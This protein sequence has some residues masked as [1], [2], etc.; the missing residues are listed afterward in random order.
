MDILQISG[1]SKSFGQNKVIRDLNLT[2]PENTIYGFIGQNGAGKTTTMKMI[3]GFLAPD[4]GEIFVKGEKVSQGKNST[5]KYIGYLPDVPEFYGYM[6]PMEYLSLCGEITGMAKAD[7]KKRANELLE[8]VG[9]AGSK[10]RIHGFSRGMRQRLGVAQ[11]LFNKPAFLICDEPTSALDPLGRKE[12]LDI[13]KSVKGETTVLF[14]THILSDVEKICDRI[15]FLND[16][17]I[18][19][20]GTLEEIRAS[21][22][23]QGLEISFEKAEDVLRFKNAFPDGEPNG[24]LQLIYKRRTKADAACFMKYIAENNI[25]IQR[26][27]ILEPTLED[28]YVSIMEKADVPPYTKKEDKK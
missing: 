18:A 22:K 13:L 9:L 11:A 3:L 4:S 16:G 20:N 15:A 12:I 27:E 8:Q 5:N 26:F 28:L 21:R 23:G 6:T 7:I 17:A 1:L 25:S 10:N 2:V 24:A 14:S 19:I